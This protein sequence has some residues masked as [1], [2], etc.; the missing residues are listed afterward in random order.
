MS[1]FKEYNRFDLRNRESGEICI[2]NALKF[3]PYI[4]TFLHLALWTMILNHNY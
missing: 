4:A 1:R 2:E 3:A